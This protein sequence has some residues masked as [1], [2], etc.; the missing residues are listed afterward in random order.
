MR[1]GIRADC[2]WLG[3]STVQIGRRLCRVQS[4]QEYSAQ[5][6]SAQEFEV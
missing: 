1:E 4:S 6:Y 2:V 5:E 3:D